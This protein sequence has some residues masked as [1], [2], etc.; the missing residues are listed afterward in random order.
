MTSGSS[1]GRPP[2]QPPELPVRPGHLHRLGLVTDR[3]GAEAGAWLARTL[4][5]VPMTGG[6]VS[7]RGF[8]VPAAGA[9]AESATD[10]ALFWLGTSPLAVFSPTDPGSPVVGFLRRY[11]PGVHSLAWTV[12]DLWT[13]EALLRRADVRITGVDVPGRHLF[14]HPRDTGGVLIEWT[15]L[16]L[17]GEPRAGAPAP[18][19]SGAPSVPVLGLAWTTALVPDVRATAD[20]LGH[21]VAVT[22]LP[23]PG[24]RRN[25]PDGPLDLAVGDTVLR[26]ATGPGT[27][28]LASFCL[29][30]AD[31][32]A[33]ERRLST[34]GIRVLH[35]TGAVLATDPADTLGL[36][37]E[38]TDRH[39]LPAHTARDGPGF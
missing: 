23:G 17:A 19:A 39:T 12:D 11:G 18:L 24:G 5:A 4:G 21:L 32:A 29:A 33:T 1:A 7:A 38:W 31:L 15:D 9:L 37:I 20:L 36:T 27:G 25:D 30:V 28:R 35:R 10:S 8:P 13:V 2:G 14:M 26:L 6:M 16:E 3:P 34:V 22:P